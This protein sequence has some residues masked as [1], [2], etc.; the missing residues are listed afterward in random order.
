METEQIKIDLLI[1]CGDFQCPRN[2]VDMKCM[3]MPEKFLSMG[4]FYK[5]YSGEKVA[6][7]PTI[8]IHGNHECVN[9]LKELYF[10]GW[11]APNI[12]Y[13][14]YSG[15][16]NFG[17]LRIGG[18]SGIYS[19]MDYRKGHMERPPYRGGSMKSAYHVRE[20]EVFKMS[21]IKSPMDI[22]LSHDW[23]R[24]IY[25]F[26]DIPSLLSRKPFFSAEIQ[27]DDLGSVA[28]QHVLLTLQ[29]KYW[30][31]AHLHVKFP[32]LL[33]HPSGGTTRFLAL[34]K[35]LPGRDFLQILDIEPS[36]PTHP[37]ATRDNE[38]NLHFYY[39][40]EWLAILRASMPLY[41][42]DIH[43]APL[44]ARL[45]LSEHQQAL[46]Q[47]VHAMRI[48]ANFQRT[49]SPYDPSQQYQPYHRMAGP[50]DN[51]QTTALCESFEIP[52]PLASNAPPPPNTSNLPQES[53]SNPI[54]SMGTNEGSAN[55]D[56]ILL[57]E[58][59]FENEG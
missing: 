32:A 10:G 44:P 19:E 38:G 12:Y 22:V 20:Y 26:G 4:S 37:Y 34:D 7:V 57:D 1:C 29:P 49:C 14:G 6:P 51:P 3:S 58:D 8:F 45:D 18:L 9:Y 41:S 27:R 56:E 33:N 25:H 28:A 40:A 50:F 35:C 31:S 59:V 53:S 42:T 46:E 16:I 36:D 48:P 54:E 11:V 5:Y 24:G 15:V 13:L 21:Q 52:L 55:P 47:K 23:P 30:F 39:D 2:E 17:G 43:Q